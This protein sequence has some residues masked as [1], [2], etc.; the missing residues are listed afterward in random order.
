MWT[1]ITRPKHARTGLRHASD[2]TA[3]EWRVIDPPCRRRR[4]WGGREG[5]ICES[6]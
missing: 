6:W 3:A 2:L 4:L 1:E 5:R